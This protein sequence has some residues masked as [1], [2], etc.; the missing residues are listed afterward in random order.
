MIIMYKKQLT[1]LANDLIQ[2]IK[3]KPDF[4]SS[5]FIVFPNAKMEQWFKSYWLKTQGDKVLMNIKCLNINDAIGEMIYTSKPY[6]VIKVDTIKHI[7]IKLLTNGFVDKLPKEEKDYIYIDNHF[8]SVKLYDY[9]SKLAELFNE[10]SND[11]FELSGYQKELYDLMNAEADINY[12]GTLEYIYDQTIHFK[13]RNEHLNFFGF[14]EFNNIQK[15]IIDDYQ[16]ENEINLYLLEKENENI[17]P[18]T[19]ISAPSKIREIEAIH[20][21]ICKNLGKKDVKY[22]DFLVVAPDISEY[23]TTIERVFKQD[24]KDFPSIPYVISAYKKNDSDLTNALIVLYDIYSKGFMTRLD[25]FKLVNNPLIQEAR[26]ISNEDVENF[27]KTIVTLNVYRDN[28]RFDDWDYIKKRLILSKVTDM[29]SDNKGL[30][31]LP[32]GEYLPYTNISFDNDSIARFVKIVDDIKSYQNV[33]RSVQCVDSYSLELIKGEFNKWF[34]ILDE[35]NMET[36]KQ[37]LRI[38]NLFNDWKELDIA[39]NRVPLNSL[40]YALIDASKEDNSSNGE[41]FTKG[42]T[43]LNFSDKDIYSAKYI[44]FLSASSK[45]LPTKVVKSELDK[46]DYE[47]NQNEKERNAF[48]LLYQNALEHFY[49]SYINRDLKTDEE[50]YPS[51]FI[52]E[53]VNRAGEKGKEIEIE[54]DER[55]PYEEL[56]TKKEYKNKDYYNGLLTHQEEE[57]EE[58]NIPYSQE[59][60]KQITIKELSKYLED[61]LMKKASRLFGYSDD[62]DADIRDEYEPFG[63]DY[64]DNYLLSKSIIAFALYNRVDL[65][66]EDAL[67]EM[68]RVFILEHA[69]PLICEPIKEAALNDLINGCK[70]TI[71]FINVKTGGSYDIGTIDPI[72]I[73]INNNPWVLSCNEDFVLYLENNGLSRTYFPVKTISEKNNGIKNNVK[74]MLEIYVISLMDI[75]SLNDNKTYHITLVRGPG[76]IAEFDVDSNTAKEVLN[77]I[78][79]SYNDYSSIHMIHVKT[80]FGKKIES[81][82]SLI[83][84]ITGQNGPWEYFD[85][86]KMFNY[87]RDFGYEH[88]DFKDVYKE[89]RKELLSLLLFV[90]DEEEEGDKN[91]TV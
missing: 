80:L 23:E 61:P 30:V 7:I 76:L 22:S 83:N 89:V 18:F 67:N 38:L 24:N 70:A 68:K 19:I 32:S 43:F 60:P 33:L 15:R 20:T 31:V 40:F 10:Y 65:D 84:T 8:D 5:T 49:V 52:N 79:I 34:S 77:K 87:E 36:S 9:A 72:I 57:T 13:K 66:D 88:E 29:N 90:E 4:F 55:R 2:Y 75:A 59:E 47:S 17:N 28:E 64:L 12:Q 27:M 58:D 91:E 1:D 82:N 63:L 50:F 37:Y 69:L 73:D 51:S 85:D 74:E 39:N 44:F 53:L 71:E 48:F 45:N 6:S 62:L 16:K 41:I 26:G 54:L 56:F 25:F 46:R 11:D 86:K 35:D 81:Y 42:I 3:E 78:Y 14:Y 21:E